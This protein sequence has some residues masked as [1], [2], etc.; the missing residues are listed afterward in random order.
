MEGDFETR[1][2]A[3]LILFGWPDMAAE[4]TATPIEIPSSAA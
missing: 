3:P 4:R 2:G 1:R